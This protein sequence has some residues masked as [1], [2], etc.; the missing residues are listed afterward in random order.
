[1]KL[2][3]Q[4]ITIETNSFG[5]INSIIFNEKEMLHDG[6]EYWQKIYP[7]IWPMTS[8]SR[9]FVVDGINYE[10]PKHGFWKE[11]AWDQVYENGSLTLLATHHANDVFPF[12]ID[13]QHTITLEENKVIVKTLF[14]NL[15][16]KTA[17]FNFGH[18]P[19]FKIDKDSEFSFSRLVRP[20]FVGLKQEVA[21]FEKIMDMPFGISYDTIV[22]HNA[23][24]LATE[25][26][27]D[28]VKVKLNAGNFDTTQLWRPKDANFICIEPWQGYNDDEYEYPVEASKKLETITLPS[29]ESTTKQISIE[30][31][32][33]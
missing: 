24:D 27:Y 4:N 31:K 5:E 29:G 2:S 15:S 10:I 6:K 21:P 14:S 26:I 23:K 30:F 1:M 19:A 28:G 3:N 7:M 8:F 13:I 16:K 18:H 11:L 22:F 32:K 9:A 25:F 17:Y 20:M 12:T 33:I